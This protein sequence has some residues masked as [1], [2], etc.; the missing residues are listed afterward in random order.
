MTTVK[1]S[2]AV[3][4]DGKT[5][6]EIVVGEPSVGAIE[7]YENAQKAEKSEMGS[8]IEMLAVDVGMPADALRKIKISDLLK[9]SEAMAPFLEALKPAS[10]PTGG[11]SAQTSPTS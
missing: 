3:N 11:P 8:M 10:G 1:L 9:I 7:A 2:K 5:Y 6:E 4:H